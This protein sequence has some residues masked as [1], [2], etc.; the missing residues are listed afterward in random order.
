MIRYLLFGFLIKLITGFDD[1]ITQ[2]PII[3]TLTKK[4]FGK[5]AFSIGI[6]LAICLA[7]IISIFFS[8][9]IRGFVYYRYI[10][11]SLL[12]L[13]AI[14]VYFDVFIH[15]ARTKA[16]KRLLKKKKISLERFTQLIGIGF[17]ASLAT[18]L[19]DII[20]YAPLFFAGAAAMIYAI[21][22]ILSATLLEIFLVI[23]FSEKIT[24]FK[25]KKELASLGLV[26]LGILVLVQII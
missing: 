20:A 17:I 22:G 26:V 21:I 19:D 24:K 15:K 18:V 10:V 2:I 25:Y 23:Y 12:F 13:L 6:F 5:I 4:R 1:T 3:S 11:T 7:I 16:E 9:F 14:L 8:S